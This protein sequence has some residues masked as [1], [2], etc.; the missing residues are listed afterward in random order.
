MEGPSPRVRAGAG[1]DQKRE[2][3][4]Q[5]LAEHAATKHSRSRTFQLS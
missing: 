4:T 5:N 1:F 2:R 3:R